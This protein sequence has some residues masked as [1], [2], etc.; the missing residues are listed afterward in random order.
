MSSKWQ[1]W[2]EEGGCTPEYH[3]CQVHHGVG[4]H[5]LRDAG[6][7]ENSVVE[8]SGPGVGETVENPGNS[9]SELLHLLLLRLG[10]G[11]RHTKHRGLLPQQRRQEPEDESHQELKYCELQF[12][13]DLCDLG[14]PTREV[15]TYRFLATLFGFMKKLLSL[16]MSTVLEDS[17]SCRKITSSPSSSPDL[18]TSLVSAGPR[19]RR[20]P[21]VIQARLTTRNCAVSLTTENDTVCLLL[22]SCHTSWASTPLTLAVSS[23][24]TTQQRRRTLASQARLGGRRASLVITYYVVLAL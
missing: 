2:R 14:L 17:L 4:R 22:S 10:S 20:R 11:Y 16:E 15:Q 18:C 12:P 8:I 5:D 7:A 9:L 21:A 23:A 6:R 13:A 1:G 24:L 3:L 19:H